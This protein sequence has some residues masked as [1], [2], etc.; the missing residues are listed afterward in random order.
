MEFKFQRH[1]IN[2]ISREEMLDELERVAKHF[3]YIEF[4]R[5]SFDKV[6]RMSSSVIRKSFDGSWKITL[7]ALKQRLN[8]KGL[9]LNPRTISPNRIFSDKDLF[10][11]LERV[12]KKVGQR[13]SKAEWESSR[14]KVSYS[15]YKQRFGGWTN[16]CLNF[17]E[18]KMGHKLILDNPQKNIK[19]RENNRGLKISKENKREIPLNL[20]LKVLDRDN[21]RCAYCG[22]SPALERGVTLHI[23]HKMPFSKGGETKLDNLQVLCSDC[24]L[25]KGNAD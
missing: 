8:S 1:Q 15:S 11:E 20:R 2:K 22:R 25:G 17:I 13:P 19:I 23:D 3:N 7:R 5:R 16:A 21:F 18:Y 24:N 12:W 10:G 6:A 14:P 9:D 4:G